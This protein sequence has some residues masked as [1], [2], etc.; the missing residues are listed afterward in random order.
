MNL[1]YY[2]N[3]ER[4]FF[5]CL[6]YALIMINLISCK[7]DELD[8]YD[9]GRG[10]LVLYNVSVNVDSNDNALTK[11]AGDFVAPQVS[12]LKYT[13]T[14]K[15]TNEVAYDEVGGFNSISLK[16]GSYKLELSYSE[17]KISTTPFL[18]ATKDFAIEQGKTTTVS[19][20][21]VELACSI[22]RPCLSEQML[23]YF[24]PSSIVITLS[25]ENTQEM[26][27]IVNN[28][29]CFVPSGKNYK[30]YISGNNT[31]GEAKSFNSSVNDVLVKNRY[32]INY[33]PN[34]PSFTIPQQNDYDVWSTKVYITPMTADNMVNLADIADKVI[35]NIV[36]EASEDNNNWI[37]SEMEGD[38]IVIKGLKPNTAYSVRSRF[39]NINSSNT[40][41]LT[42][43]G[44]TQIPNSGMEQWSQTKL[45]SGNG[46]W[47]ANIYC[48][49]CTSWNTRNERTTLGAEN[50]NSG[51][52]FGTNKGSGYGVKYRW[53]S[54]TTPVSDVTE[55]TNAAQIATLAF[56]NKNVSGVWTRTDILKSVQGDGSPFA[57]YLFTGTFN[58]STDSYDLGISHNARPESISFDY[59]YTP[60]SG[61]KSIAYAKLYD[62]DKNIIAETEVFNSSEQS[63]YLTRTLDFVYTTKNKKAA[64]IGV[65]FQSGTDLDMNKMSQIQGDY[66]I[67][68]F[69]QDYVA[70]SVLTIDN[71]KLNY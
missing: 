45:Y 28:Q 58:K 70:G 20:V 35:A 30:V 5:W 4:T 67:S 40:L 49:Y 56:Y 25:E 3:K 43:E 66:N 37:Q 47:S 15:V 17:N 50:A 13:I 54:G 22:I 68:P 39:Q 48:D 36:Y 38:R 18:Y 55:G 51:G 10:T 31:L 46:T 26:T 62:S 11:S 6:F 8:S 69:N 12:E 19:G 71:V 59:K 60:V 29:D 9:N 33:S 57:G 32:I 53:R 34:V 27:P 1:N 64:Y 65:F 24:E 7:D 2:M 16:P 52:I 44:A 61:D 21:V 63:E 41:S 42:T 23:S 14:D